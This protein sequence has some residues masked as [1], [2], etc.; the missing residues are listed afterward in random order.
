MQKLQFLLTSDSK[1]EC[2]KRLCN[3]CNKKQPSGHFCY[4]AP[5][6]PRKLSS[7]FMYVFFDAERTQ[8]LEK[9]E[10]SFEHVPKLICA[11]QMCSQCQASEDLSVD[12][13]QCGKRVHVFR[14]DP[15]GKFIEYLRQSTPFAEKILV[16]SHNSRGYDAHFLLRRFLELRWVPKLIMDGTKILSMCVE[17]I[18]FMD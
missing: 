11:E 1:H 8:D 13:K 18:Q 5:L 15:V 10:G 16:I 7:R 14:Q 4:M 6:K 2:F 9:H 3:I 17:H 12:C